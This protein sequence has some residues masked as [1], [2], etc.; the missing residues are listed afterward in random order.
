MKLATGQDLFDFEVIL[1]IT[2]RI[3]LL[4]LWNV[5]DRKIIVAGDLFLVKL[6]PCA[7]CTFQILEALQHVHCT[8][9]AQCTTTFQV[10][11]HRRA[12]V[13]LYQRIKFR[14]AP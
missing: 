6:D 2:R 14:V 5:A 8:C 12:L 10:M 4:Y 7:L 1:T 11:H 9:I 13:E 3:K